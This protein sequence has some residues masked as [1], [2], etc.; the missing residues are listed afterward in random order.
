M[1]T[2]PKLTVNYFPHECTHGRKMFIIEEKYGNDGYSTWFKLL[3]QLGRAEN[4]YLDITDYTQKS[5]L[6]SYCK[7]DEETFDNILKTLCDLGAIHKSLLTDYGIIW[8]PKF[9]ESIEDAYKKRNAD[10]MDYER[11]C[12]HLSLSTRAK[13]G[14]LNETSGEKVVINPQIKLNKNKGEET[15]V[16]ENKENNLVNTKLGK[17][18]SDI[19]ELMI[20]FEQQL[21]SPLDGTQKMNRYA[22][23]NLLKRVKKIPRAADDPV[24]AIKVLIQRGIADN[25]HGKNMTKFKYINDHLTAI[26]NAVKGE[27]TSEERYLRQTQ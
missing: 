12:I 22:C 19:S 18:N 25:F 7:I 17:P 9:S 21:G 8:N 13:V 23:N 3:E 1:A 26:I 20:Y 16:K 24:G 4:H 2:K 11:L 10:L 14:S 27:E 5:Y 15:K 6:I